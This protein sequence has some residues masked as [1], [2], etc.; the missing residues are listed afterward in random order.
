MYARR[1]DESAVLVV[2]ARL[3][4]EPEC[5]PAAVGAEVTTALCGHWEHDGPCRWPHNNAIEGDAPGPATF[6]TIV[7]VDPTEREQVRAR[8]EA[9]LSAFDAA[10]LVSAQERPLDGAAERELAA[11]LL[12]GPRATVSS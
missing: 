5:D 11:K 3:A 9:S 2:E 10:L 4:L 7:V 6:R 8:V 12:A 1:V